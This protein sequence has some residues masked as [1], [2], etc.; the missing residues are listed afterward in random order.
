VKLRDSVMSPLAPPR[1]T[2]VGA[3]PGELRLPDELMFAGVPRVTVTTYD[4]SSLETTRVTRLEQL[5]AEPEA[6]KV[7][8]ISIEGLADLGLFRYLQRTFGIH[9]LAIEDTLSRRSRP[10]T[11]AHHNIVNVI[12]V[13]PMTSDPANFG[14]VELVSLFLGD[15]WVISIEDSPGDTF[16]AVHHRLK[17]VGSRLRRGGADTLLQ[18]LID[19]LVDRFFPVLDAFNERL[20]EL[21]ETVGEDTTAALSHELHEIRQALQRLRR[22]AWPMREAVNALTR[23]GFVNISDTLYPYLMDVSDHLAQVIDQVEMQRE[24]ATSIR[25]LHFSA[26]N[27]KMNEIIRGLTVVSTIFLPLTFLTGIYGM[28]FDHLPYSDKAW[29]FWLFFAMMVALGG[30]MYVWFKRKRWA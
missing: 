29:A 28:N 25:D 14:E 20:E 15:N 22:Y 19:T 10:K 16:E 2:R 21:D 18:A 8:W 23:S 9:P 24:L 11:E 27:M 26:L 3:P 30:A 12:A 1:K 17:H 5:P 7:L 4:N 13:D 6:G